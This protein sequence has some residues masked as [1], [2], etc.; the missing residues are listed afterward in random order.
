[1]CQKKDQEIEMLIKQKNDVIIALRNAIG[2]CEYCLKKYYKHS[3]FIN[4]TYLS[5]KESLERC[6]N[7]GR[8]IIKLNTN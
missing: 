5:E 7:Q 1:M 8:D 4:A 2:H 3:G 6:I